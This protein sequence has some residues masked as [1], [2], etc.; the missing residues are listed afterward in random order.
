MQSGKGAAVIMGGHAASPDKNGSGTGRLRLRRGKVSA[1]GWLM[2]MLLVPL[3]CSAQTLETVP[4]EVA[5]VPRAP[6]KLDGE[7]LFLVRGVSAFPAEKRAAAIAERIEAV[8]KDPA[9]VTGSLQATEGDGFTRIEARGQMLVT[10]TNA[11]A[12]AEGVGRRTLVNVFIPRL[13]SAISEYRQARTRKAL[14]QGGLRA[15]ATLAAFIVFLFL[16]LWAY[17]RAEAATER[18]CKTRVERFRVRALPVVETERLWVALRNALRFIRASILVISSL[19]AANLLLGQ[20]PWTKPFSKSAFELILGPLRAIGQGVARSVPDLAFLVVLFIVFR[21]LLKLIQAVFEAIT[22]GTLSFKGFDPEWAGPTFRIVRMLVIAF[23]LIVAYPYLPGSGSEAFKGVSLFIGVIFSLGSSGMISNIMAGYSLT[24]RRAYKVGD[25]VRIGD[26]IGDVETTRLQ[27]THLRSLKN[28]EVIIPNSVILNSS[29]VNYTSLAK[30]HGLILHTT[31]GIGYET[32]WRQVEAMLLVA[33][34][35]TPGFLRVPPP[36]VLH[37]TLGDFCVTYELNAY[38]DQ[39][40]EQ[41][42]LY[43]ALHRNILDVFNEHGVQIMT[44]AYEGDPAEPKVV[45]K[46]K[47]FERP[48]KPPLPPEG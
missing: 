27:V 20:F 26:I 4:E 18:Y 40:G 23:G 17:R 34:E 29:V 22:R 24:Y 19:F 10:V 14:M 42:Q 8:A 44:P 21:Y 25:R 47:W 16:F 32:P 12:A 15:V 5:V 35:R 41:M 9:Y 39:P 48:A 43:T 13:D 46:D 45:P 37:S 3:L 30:K 36:F 38:C 33:A 2:T 6:V 28:E 7:T 11:D 1:G 31:V